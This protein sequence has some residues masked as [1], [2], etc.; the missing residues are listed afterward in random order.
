MIF[1]FFL[2]ESGDRRY[3]RFQLRQ[4][5]DAN[6]FVITNTLFL[7]PTI[8]HQFCA[9]TRHRCKS[10]CYHKHI[11]FWRQQVFDWQI[12]SSTIQL[13]K[14]LQGTGKHLKQDSFAR[15]P[16]HPPPAACAAS[17][18]NT[19]ACDD[20]LYGQD[21]SHRDHIRCSDFHLV[22]QVLRL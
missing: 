21:C 4:D 3:T 15:F 20:N 5:I 2:K 10:I 19:S 22:L 7:A 1:S 6:T 11:R 16:G 12:L 13:G 14:K 17:R 18:D 9:K 8:I